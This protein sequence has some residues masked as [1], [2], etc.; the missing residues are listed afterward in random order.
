[1]DFDR[2]ASEFLRALRGKR[3]QPAF[4]RR[5]GYKSNVAYTW[6]SGRGF[7]TAARALWAAERVGVPVV[8]AYQEFYQRRPAWLQEADPATPEGVARFLTDLKGRTSILELA[9][10]SGKSRFAVA[11]WLK[12]ETEPKLPEFFQ[13]VECSSLRL[14]DYLEQLVDPRT[15]P[16]LRGRWEAIQTARRLAYDA[17]WTQAVLRAM[18]L[19]AYKQLER[20]EPGWIA[21]RIGIDAE[22]EAESLAL[23][24]QT[25]QVRFKNGRYTLGE[26]PALDTR[27]NP[28]AALKLRTWWGQQA[29]ERFARGNRGMMYN[30]ISVSTADLERLRELQKAYFNE[31]RTIVAQSQPIERVALATVQLLDLGEAPEATPS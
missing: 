14:V 10:Y 11:R 27:K 22:V 24:A 2:L 21:A 5:L 13:L 9:S 31:V 16:S 3:S 20:H 29:L 12:G 28:A 17:P 30:L 18:E 6:E 23:L 1:M 19:D 25:G 4:C 26:I 7:P 8:S 15:L